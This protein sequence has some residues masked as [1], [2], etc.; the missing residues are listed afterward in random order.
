MR[1][2][3]TLLPCAAGASVFVLV[4]ACQPRTQDGAPP[5]GMPPT[6]YPAYPPGQTPPGYPPGQTPPS[7]PPPGSTVPMATGARISRTRDL[8]RRKARYADMPSGI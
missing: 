8:K 2:L 3:R 1:T 5:N 4:A 6:G 7:Y